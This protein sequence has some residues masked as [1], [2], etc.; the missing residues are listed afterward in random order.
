MI[1][2]GEK[3]D[4]LY[5]NGQKTDANAKTVNL[6]KGRNTLVAGFIYDVNRFKCMRN[7]SKVKRATILFRKN[8]E[9]K[10]T[11]IPLSTCN[12]AN[13]EYFRFVPH[14]ETGN[15]CCFRFT[16]VPGFKSFDISLF[17]TL[18]KAF[19]DNEEMQI[20]K[21]SQGNFG[22]QK[23]EAKQK[24]ASPNATQVI[25]FVKAKAGFSYTSIIPEPVNLRTGNNAVIR[26]GDTSKMGALECYSGKLVYEKTVF[27]KNTDKKYIL[28]L[29]DVGATA[30]IE[31]NAE[32]A[33]VLTFAPFE[34]DISKYLTDGENKLKITVS[35]TL[36]NHYSTI[37]SR[38]SSFPTDAKSGLIGPV[39]INII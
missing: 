18:I 12:F 4:F 3:A 29:G 19:S 11:D 26:L 34:A 31:I 16:S 7:R 27:L 24:E 2:D 20:T 22:T 28:S 8:K 25:F 36:C 17:G 21:L 15:I 10:K 1:T 33:A 6:H 32:T 35:N 23:Y 30:K 38:Y 37:P 14:G 9:V 5:L 13:N 39:K